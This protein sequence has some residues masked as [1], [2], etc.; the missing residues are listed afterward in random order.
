MVF[1]EKTPNQRVF[2]HSSAC[3]QIP[4]V[5]GLG[6]QLLSSKST[7]G[8]LHN[9]VHSHESDRIHEEVRLDGVGPCGFSCV[10]SAQWHRVSKITVYSQPGLLYLSRTITA[11]DGSFRSFVSL[12]AG[13]ECVGQHSSYCA[14]KHAMNS[15]VLSNQDY[16]PREVGND[17]CSHY[18]SPTDELIRRLTLGPHGEASRNCRR[19]SVISTTEAVSAHVSRQ[20]RNTPASDLSMVRGYPLTETHGE[21]AK[22]EP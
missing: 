6:A 7:P 14:L 17:G 16:W 10:I 4:T 2:L 19:A 5:I 8:K 15:A 18:E 20:P 21:V 12:V 22:R 3:G 11:F 13:E 9:F 1:Y